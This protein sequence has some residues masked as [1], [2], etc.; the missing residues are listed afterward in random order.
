M[1]INKNLNKQL[2]L[3]I[4]FCILPLK[5]L[6][7]DVFKLK[8]EMH[9]LPLGLHLDI[10]EDKKGNI[11][12]NDLTAKGKQ[13]NYT[14]VKS[15]KKVNTYGYTDSVYW[16]RFIIEN[17]SKV[18]LQWYLEVSLPTIDNIK[19]YISDIKDSYKIKE[20]GDSVS[21]NKRDIKTQ[22]CFLFSS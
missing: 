12:I 5:L 14:W 4:V 6:G 20:T 10:L 8:K 9:N 22:N 11:R 19:L 13:K 7:Q 15:T 21:F 18:D 17:P 3:L 1:R 2:T 16:V